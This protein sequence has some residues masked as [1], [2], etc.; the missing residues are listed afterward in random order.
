MDDTS[1][2]VLFSYVPYAHAKT[3]IHV[4]TFWK[5]SV[6]KKSV[7]TLRIQAEDHAS[8]LGTLTRKITINP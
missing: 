2:A 8:N 4:D 7:A 1:N 3:E 5:S 6:V